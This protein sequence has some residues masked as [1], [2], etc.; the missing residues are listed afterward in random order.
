MNV[1]R[2][3]PHVVTL[4]LLGLSVYSKS[5]ALS[6]ASVLSLAVVMVKNV[7]DRMLEAKEAR[8]AAVP[9]ESKKQ[10]HDLQARITTL[11]YWVKTHLGGGQ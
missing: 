9:E 5:A 3:F 11:E 6:Y 10:M 2:F 7:Y 4:V 8:V 1:E